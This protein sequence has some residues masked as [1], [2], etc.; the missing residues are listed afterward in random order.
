MERIDFWAEIPT[1][2][3]ILY[4]ADEVHLFLVKFNAGEK[5]KLLLSVKYLFLSQPV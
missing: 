2:C 1:C 3:W 5:K 4:K